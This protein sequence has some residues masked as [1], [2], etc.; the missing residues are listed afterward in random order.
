[1]K[2]INVLTVTFHTPGLIK[3]MI[4]SFEKF[5]PEDLDITYVVVE[6]S[7]DSLGFRFVN[8]TK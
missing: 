2:K 7:R 5:K 1:M 8:L 4:N 6:N 3:S